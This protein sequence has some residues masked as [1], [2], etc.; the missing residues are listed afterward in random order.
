MIN[1]R[2]EGVFMIR[3]EVEKIYAK[4]FEHSME[5]VKL[6]INEMVFTWQWWLGVFLTIAPWIFWLKFKKNQ[7]TD[8][9]LLAGFFV[10]S[11][12]SWIDYMGILFG[13]WEYDYQ[14]L[15]TIIS[16][17]P[18]SVSLYPVAIM[19]FLQFR[20]D[21]SPYI[22]GLVFSLITSFIVEPF[23][24]WTG[25]YTLIHWE[26]IY[27]FLLNIVTYLVAHYISRR[28]KFQQL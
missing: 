11:I 1:K 6:W 25:N 14:V 20:P 28:N 7:S 26:Y 21:I 12:T 24:V 16:Y 23:F 10:I 18:W 17:I 13:L 27:S 15:P 5:M 19:F 2:R 8:R 3:P 22:K 4:V 9:L